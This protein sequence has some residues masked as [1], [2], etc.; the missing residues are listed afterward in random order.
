[1]IEAYAAGVNA[2]LDRDDQQYG[3]ELTVDQAAVGRPLPAGTVAARQFAGVGQADGAGAGRQLARRAAA[4]A[5]RA[6]DRRGRREVPDRGAGRE[7]RLDAVA[8][9]RGAERHRSRPA[10]SRH[11]QHRHAQARGL[12]RMGA[13]GRAFGF[14]QAAARQRPASCPRPSPAPGISPAWSGR[15][16]TFAAPPRPARPPSC[17]A[18]TAR[19]A[20]A[21]PPPTST[22]RTCSS[23]GSIRPIPNRYITPD[24]ARPFAV[25]DETINVAVGRSGDDAR[26]QHAPRRG[27]RRFH[28]PARRYSRRRPRAGAAGD[29]ARRRRHLGRGLAAH[30]PGAELGTTSS[31]A[32]R[33]IVSPM[34]NMVYADTAGNIGLVSPA[35]VPIR[36]KGDGSM[37]VARLDVGIRLGGLRAVRRV[38]ADLQSAGR[39]HRQRQRPRGARRLPLL[40]HPRLGRALPPAPRQPAAARGRTPSGL[41]HDRHAGRQSHARRRRHAAAPAEGRAAQRPRRPG[42]RAD[43][44]L[45]PLHAGAPAPSR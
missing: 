27:D 44:P 17:S 26:A 42:A 20:G 32:A 16:S 9:Q 36:R 19:S 13:V 33:K 2:W 40:H 6:Q 1:M 38:A 29:R 5:A 7:S 41:R 37:P 24:G 30:Q 4:P 15:A 14:G 22:A 31:N 34:Q 35:R 8:G 21:S 45:E 18:T 3:L 12:E 10:L 25:R 28:P 23:S 11:R 43:G 39:H